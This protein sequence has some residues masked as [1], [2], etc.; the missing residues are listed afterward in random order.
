M[1]DPL[2]RTSW[3]HELLALRQPEDGELGRRVDQM[4]AALGE[5]KLRHLYEEEIRRLGEHAALPLLR[6]LASSAEGPDAERRHTAA[7]LSADLAGPRDVPD[8]IELL[9]DGDAEVRSH[10]ARG[11][12]RLTGYDQGRTPEQWLSDSWT[13]CEP[14]HR[15]W[16]QWWQENRDRYPA[17]QP[18][19]RSKRKK[20]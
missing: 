14:S 15:A 4:L 8:L 20:A 6:C 11:L 17:R 9:A 2:L 7:R 19:P 18:A 16:Q 1:H 13:A 12:Q 3:T 10:A 5:A